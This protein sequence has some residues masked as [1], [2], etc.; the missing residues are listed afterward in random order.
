MYFDSVCDVQI[1]VD[2][3]CDAKHYRHGVHLFE[4][5]SCARG[6]KYLPRGLHSSETQKER[7]ALSEYALLE[8]LTGYEA[9]AKRLG[10]VINAVITLV[11]EEGA[12]ILMK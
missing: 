7:G 5:V 8:R 1:I 12:K 3:I 2:I 11:R 6:R 4:G 10:A 9:K